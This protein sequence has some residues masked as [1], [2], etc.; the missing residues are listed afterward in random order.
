MTSVERI[1][2]YGNLRQEAPEHISSC[3]PDSWPQEGAITF[4]GI[5]LTYRAGHAPALQNITF[6]IKPN[7]KV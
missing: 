5:T 3:L 4:D 6:D 7:E 2:Q 1:K